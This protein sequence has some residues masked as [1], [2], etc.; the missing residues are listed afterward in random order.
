MG[1]GVVDTRVR[2]HTSVLSF[3]S[4]GAASAVGT[5]RSDLAYTLSFFCR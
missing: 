3:S 5:A 4:S 1:E 2:A